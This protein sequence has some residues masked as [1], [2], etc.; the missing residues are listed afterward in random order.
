MNNSE[1]WNSNQIKKISNN[2]LFFESTLKL[3]FVC[4]CSQFPE[5]IEANAAST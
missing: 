3:I 4:H 2:Q 1:V 5:S